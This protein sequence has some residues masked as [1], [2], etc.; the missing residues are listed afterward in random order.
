MDDEKSLSELKMKAEK[1]RDER[2]WLKFHTPKNLAVS[3]SIEA[4]EMLELFQWK[5]PSAEEVLRE[6]ELAEALEEELADILIYCLNVA[7]V[8]NI[9][10]SSAI[11]RKLEANN[12]KYPAEE[13]RG[14]T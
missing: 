2:D 11:E 7:N 12:E 6:K 8:L 5:D 10:L 3:I 13:Y 4:A 14:R 9:D 1:F